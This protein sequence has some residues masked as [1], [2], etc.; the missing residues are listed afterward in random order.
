MN[1]IINTR[2]SMKLNVLAINHLNIF[3]EILLNNHLNAD[4]YKMFY[5]FYLVQRIV[6]S[7]KFKI[8]D[9]FIYPNDK[10]ANITLSLILIVLLFLH[11]YR[12]VFGY[13]LLVNYFNSIIQI[14]L[15]YF[16]SVLV[17]FE[18]TVSLIFDIINSENNILQVLTIQMIQERVILSEK[19]KKRFIICN[20]IANLSVLFVALAM[21][22]RF[23]IP[24][25]F[26][27]IV[28]CFFALLW[29]ITTLNVIYAIQ[30]IKLLRTLLINWKNHVLGQHGSSIQ[31]FDTFEKFL[32]AYIL[33]KDIFKATVSM[34]YF[35]SHHSD[36]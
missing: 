12:L 11:W 16:N 20:W 19:Y 10:K 9:K 31:V 34:I 26:Y 23:S 33:Y 29:E 36:I 27:G 30:M 22:M 35:G 3:E 13:H 28:T 21:V 4:I 32:Q 7:M 18:I 8:K 14:I 2:N 1:S 24:D 25:H 17:T 5:P 15:M 6:P